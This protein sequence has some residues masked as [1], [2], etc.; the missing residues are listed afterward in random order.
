MGKK[1]YQQELFSLLDNA[2]DEE[3]QTWFLFYKIFEKDNIDF[4][5]KY[6]K[7]LEEFKKNSKTESWKNHL[8]MIQHW[9]SG[10]VSEMMIQLDFLW[11]KLELKKWIK[12]NNEGRTFSYPNKITMVTKILREGKNLVQNIFPEILNN[13]TSKH[14]IKIKETE[15][16]SGSVDWEKTIKHNISRGM[17]IPTKFVTKSHKKIFDTSEN[18]LAILSMKILKNNIENILHDSELQ[19]EIPK[20][21]SMYSEIIHLNDHAEK[22]LNDPRIYLIYKKYRNNTDRKMDTKKFKNLLDTVREDINERKI[23]HSSQKPYKSLIDWVDKFPTDHNIENILGDKEATT[24]R[25]S[26][27]D[28]IDIIYELWIIHSLIDVLKKNEIKL[29]GPIENEKGA[30][31]GYNLAYKKIKFQLLYDKEFHFSTDEYDDDEIKIKPDFVLIS[32]DQKFAPVVMD[33]KNYLKQDEERIS[34]AKE[35]LLRYRN[36]MDKNDLRTTKTIGFF[37]EKIENKEWVG[38]RKMKSVLVQLDPKDKKGFKKN[39]HK[40]HDKIF[41]K[42]IEE[43]EE[44]EKNKIM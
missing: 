5:N 9:N 12:V 39:L 23:K 36:T 7:E 3:I 14:S 11:T 44:Y 16:Y 21:S 40:L 13:L 35:T 29:L 8:R 1:T 20:E 6:S 34:G 30:F 43:L 26:F 32:E 2:S 25:V 4:C 33:A 19:K 28:S 22:L 10:G 15:N 17:V 27:S 31:G 38:E 41:S 18:I 42:V 37:P 24:V